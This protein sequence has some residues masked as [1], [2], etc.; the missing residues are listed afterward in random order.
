MKHPFFI[1]AAALLLLAACSES[2][3]NLVDVGDPLAAAGSPHFIANATS[4]AQEGNNLVCDF[5]EAGLAAGTIVTIAVTVSANTG[6]GCVNGGGTVPSDP[7]KSISGN[8]TESDDFTVPKNG[9]LVASLTVSPLP[10]N[11]ALSCPPGQRATLISVTYFAPAL[12]EDLDN[13]AAISI[14]SFE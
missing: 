12:I 8:L 7:K 2:S 5:K 1:S 3:S 11:Q 14:S 9:N 4:C 6:Y 10:A 13:D